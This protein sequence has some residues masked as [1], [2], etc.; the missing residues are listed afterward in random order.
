MHIKAADVPRLKEAFKETYHRDLVESSLRQFRDDFE[1]INE[2][3]PISR[4]GI[5]VGKK[6]YLDELINSKGDISYHPRGKGLTSPSIDAQGDP[7]KLYQ[8][9]FDEEYV[10]FDVTE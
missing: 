5:F 9:L 7:I 10:E 2:D 1:P 6:F 4:L 8:R 3:T